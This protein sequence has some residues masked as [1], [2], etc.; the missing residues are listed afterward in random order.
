MFISGRSYGNILKYKAFYVCM[1]FILMALFSTI[2]TVKPAFAT[3]N[4]HRIHSG[5]VKCPEGSTPE[6]DGNSGWWGCSWKSFF[7]KDPVITCTKGWRADFKTGTRKNEREGIV[8]NYKLGHC[9]EVV[10]PPN[11]VE[12]NAEALANKAYPQN[13]LVDLISS[14]IEASPWYSKLSDANMVA[15]GCKLEPLLPG[16]SSPDKTWVCDDAAKKKLAKMLIGTC[17]A[18]AVRTVAKRPDGQDKSNEQIDKLFT[19]CI[20]KNSGVNAASIN[21]KKYKIAWD[22]IKKDVETSDSTE[23][24][25]E[26]GEPK[27]SCSD[28]LVLGWLICPSMSLAGKLADAGYNSVSMFLDISPDIFKDN[29]ELGGA[30]QAW[31]FFRDIANV[32]FV[33][34]FLWVIFSQISNVG[35]SNYDIKKILPKLIL[36][37]ILINL[38]FYICQL[39]VDLSNILGYALKGVLEGASLRAEPSEIGVIDTFVTAIEK[40]LVLVGTALFAFLTV[41]IPMLMWTLVSIG[42]AL[43]ILVFRQAA[44]I[45]L[46]AISPIAFAAWLLPNTES[47]FKKWVSAFKGLLVVFPVVSL[48]YGSGKLAGAV[49]SHS[50]SGIIM[51]FVALCA[52]IVPLIATPFVIKSSLNSLGSI[53][54]KISNNGLMNFPSNKLKDNV[55][56]KS[57]FADAKKSFGRYSAKKLAESRSGNSWSQNLKNSNNKFARTFGKAMSIG[58]T[59][60]NTD[61]LWGFGRKLGLSEAA[62][63]YQEA[64]D[65]NAMEKAERALTYKYGGDAAAALNDEDADKY[66]RIAATN[67]LKSQ[68]TYGADK[69]AKYLSGGGKVDSVSMAKSLTDMKGSHAGVAEAGAEAL[70]AF[71]EENGPSEINF[72]SDQFNNLTA[73]GV[74]KLSYKDIAGQSAKAI[75]KSNITADQATEILS[76]DMLYSSTNKAVRDALIAKGGKRIIP[77]TPQDNQNDQQ[78]NNSQQ[79]SQNNQQNNSNSGGGI[80]IA[81]SQGDVRKALEDSKRRGN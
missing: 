72:S 79:S 77:Q 52:P 53:G 44:V 35:V 11:A 62:T 57:R 41:S 16:T 66:I 19:D 38:S 64:Y 69:I 58:T 55:M 78:G 49:L 3:D 37:A 18:S 12:K 40:A 56:N 32:V 14:K 42:V 24:K 9:V 30:K 73:S 29:P 15:A 2:L 76:D 80:I 48:M 67:Q 5:S 10:S 25:D 13:K 8:T 60:D 17:I 74:E 45:L 23:K 75:E 6:Q 43:L 7:P 47:L 51:Q 20:A 31:N 81:T 39:A 50:S 27:K 36:G 21:D 59:L 4:P 71:Q 65:K 70:K 22:D 46:I 26:D 54:A 1:S 28:D 63:N 33:L 68:G 61:R 34:L